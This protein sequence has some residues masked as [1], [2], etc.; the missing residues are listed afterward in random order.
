MQNPDRADAIKPSP[1]LLDR[2]RMHEEACGLIPEAFF[3][4]V[5]AWEAAPGVIVCRE[6]NGEHTIYFDHDKWKVREG[7]AFR[8]I[9][10]EIES[11]P[12][13]TGL[14]EDVMARNLESIVNTARMSLEPLEGQS[15]AWHEE[16]PISLDSELPV[17]RDIG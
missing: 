2:I 8:D 15:L 7:T 6:E 12:V 17:Y 14:I 10:P 13:Q 3:E 9:G 4:I 16:G 11:M 5:H 1:P